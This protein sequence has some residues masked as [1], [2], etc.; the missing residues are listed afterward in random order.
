VCVVRERKAGMMSNKDSYRPRTVIITGGA[1]GLGLATA[2]RLCRDGIIVITVDV[3]AA[4]QYVFRPLSKILCAWN[5][6]IADLAARIMDHFR[7]W[8]QTGSSR[9][10]SEVGCIISNCI[11]LNI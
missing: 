8:F 1:S 3:D 4:A 10:V 9:F 2:E 6:D 7:Y 11:C 5:T